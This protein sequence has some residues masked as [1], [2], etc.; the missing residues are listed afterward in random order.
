MINQKTMIDNFLKKLKELNFKKGRKY[1]TWYKKTNEDTFFVLN[2]QKSQ[3]SNNYYFNIGITYNELK[4]HSDWDFK[5]PVYELGNT[6]A[7]AEMYIEDYNSVIKQLMLGGVPNDSSK[8][9]QEK[10]FDYIINL[11][12]KN[13]TKEE[14]KKNYKE[15]Y[16]LDNV[17]IGLYLEEYCEN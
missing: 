13:S 12:N 10:I 15:Y 1:N 6:H 14:F 3:W 17:A 9:L 8:E 7:R 11:F 4:Q 2:F 16:L 5:N